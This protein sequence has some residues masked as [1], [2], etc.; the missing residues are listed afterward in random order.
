MAGVTNLQELLSDLSEIVTKRSV[1]LSMKE[2]K[3]HQYRKGISH[4]LDNCWEH[5][6]EFSTLVQFHVNNAAHYH[7]FYHRCRQFKHDSHKALAGIADYLCQGEQ[8]DPRLFNR[9]L[10]ESHQILLL[11]GE[12]L[13]NLQDKVIDVAPI[14]QR[15]KSMNTQKVTEAILLTAYRTEKF[16]FY[17]NEK[18]KVVQIGKPFL[19]DTDADSEQETLGFP[20][21]S[22]TQRTLSTNSMNSYWMVQSLDGQRAG[23][24]PSI[25]LWTSGPDDESLL[26]LKALQLFSTFLDRLIE[27]KSVAVKQ[28]SMLKSFLDELEYCLT[29]SNEAIDAV[30]NKALLKKITVIRSMITDKVIT[31]QLNAGLKTM[32]ISCFEQILARIKDHMMTA[33]LF[34]TDQSEIFKQ[35]KE[36]EV[37]RKESLAKMQSAV[38]LIEATNKEWVKLNKKISEMETNA[39][40]RLEVSTKWFDSGYDVVEVDDMS[41][42]SLEEFSGFRRKY[43]TETVAKQREIAL[44]T[45]DQSMQVQMPI[46]EEPRYVTTKMIELASMEE[47]TIRKEEIRKEE[48]E[49]IYGKNVGYAADWVA[50]KEAFTGMESGQTVDEGMQTWVP[51]RRRTLDT[52]EPLVHNLPDAVK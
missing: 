24:V 20:T 4:G 10:K 50:T 25:C 33:R 29:G 43:R 44:I 18:V 7:Q 38:K 8:L 6:R 11:L 31:V 48:F 47:V 39:Q 13:Q 2:L 27:S 17:R 5:V 26:V 34:E 15:I 21:L 41:D 3:E 22:G 35:E 51:M 36:L 37:L 30:G 14:Y 40:E 1:D 9:V 23:Y 49:A 28:E 12:Q 32:E 46:R 42:Y 45:H 16:H 52:D 19:E